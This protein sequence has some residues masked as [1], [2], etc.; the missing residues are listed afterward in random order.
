VRQAAGGDGPDTSAGL[1]RHGRLRLGAIER[2][3]VLSVSAMLFTLPDE[4]QAAQCTS[5]SKIT[6]MQSV[7]S[8]GASRLPQ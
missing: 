3:L 6:P 7:P 1:E 2:T 4:R 5:E 8:Q